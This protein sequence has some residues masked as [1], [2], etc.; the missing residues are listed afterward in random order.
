MLQIL[1]DNLRNS[2]ISEHDLIEE[3][4]IR[5][6]DR[7]EQVKAA[8]K[9]RSGEISVIPKRPEPVVVPITVAEGVQTVRV[10]ICA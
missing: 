9:E 6:V 3:L 8:Y 7:P 5:G 4:R 1:H 2:H 10:E